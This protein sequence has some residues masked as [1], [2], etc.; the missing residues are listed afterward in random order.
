M[1]AGRPALEGP[2]V[3][4]AADRPAALSARNRRTALL[5]LA[6]V[7]LLAAASVAVAWLRN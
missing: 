6:W 5:L 1:R 4:G 3:P 7:A 2:A